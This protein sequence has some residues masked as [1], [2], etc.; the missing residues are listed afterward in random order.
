MDLNQLR[1][2]LIRWARWVVV[3]HKGTL[4][5]A[6]S[7]YSE[8]IGQG[9][10]GEWGLDMDQEILS[11]DE[12]YRSLPEPLR[13]ILATHYLLPGQTKSKYEPGKG[14]EYFFKKRLAEEALLSVHTHRVQQK[15]DANCH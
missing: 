5:Y 4:G 11:L 8:M 1:D 12:S 2:L 3:G 15:E 10:Y 7:R 6:A 13:Q 14:R 9:S